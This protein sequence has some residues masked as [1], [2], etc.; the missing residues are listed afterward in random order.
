M[1]LND[2][3]ESKLE[4]FDVKLRTFFSFIVT[5]GFWTFDINDGNTERGVENVEIFETLKLSLKPSGC[6]GLISL[7]KRFSQLR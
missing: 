1:S 2:M 7:C 3:L 4:R 6:D 5:R